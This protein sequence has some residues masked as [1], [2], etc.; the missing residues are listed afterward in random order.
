MDVQKLLSVLFPLVK[1][2][3]RCHYDGRPG[4]GLGQSAHSHDRFTQA[5]PVGQECPLIVE[6]ERH[7]LGLIRP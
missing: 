6:Q 1:N 4:V 7:T 3:W 2:V 5:Y